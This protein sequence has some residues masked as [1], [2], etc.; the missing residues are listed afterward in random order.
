[1]IV[2]VRE[3]S[4]SIKRKK[5]VSGIGKEKKYKKGWEEKRW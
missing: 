4:V 5:K 2:V 1:M 3:L